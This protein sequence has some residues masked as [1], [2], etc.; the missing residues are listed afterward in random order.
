MRGQ[1]AE[2]ATT[3]TDD[4]NKTLHTEKI[5]AES[6]TYFFDIK[7]SRDGT[8]YLC[9]TETRSTGSEHERHRVMVFQEHME[10]FHDGYLKAAELFDVK[11]KAYGVD[12]IREDHADAYQT[13]TPEEDNQLAA[14]YNQGIDINDLAKTFQRQSSAIRSRLSKLG[15]IPLHAENKKAT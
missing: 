10:A 5:A 8:R 12:Q 4:H 3:M 11:T 15:L 7:E 13:W 6:R 9:I 14:Q 1:L 2:P